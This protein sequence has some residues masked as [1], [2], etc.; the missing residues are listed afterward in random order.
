M[1]K[2]IERYIRHQAVDYFGN[3]IQDSISRSLDPVTDNPLMSKNI[4]TDV[5][6]SGT[7]TNIEHKL[8]RAFRGWFIVDAN[9]NTN[10]WRDA[11]ST[12]D[13]TKFLPLVAGAAVTVDI[14]VF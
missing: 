13:A 7:T 14:Y 10:V 2:F 1:G 11:A 6:L 3:A 4:L 5:A 12:A 8:G 9:A